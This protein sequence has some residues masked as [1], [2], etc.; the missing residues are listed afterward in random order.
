MATGR[1]IPATEYERAGEK[2]SLLPHRPGKDLESENI[3]VVDR[4]WLVAAWG[5]RQRVGFILA[6]AELVLFGEKSILPP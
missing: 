4:R 5:R 2:E 6:G 3:C 1:A